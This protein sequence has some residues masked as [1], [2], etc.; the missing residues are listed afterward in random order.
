MA[1]VSSFQIQN[2]EV[3]FFTPECKYLPQY[4]SVKLFA[5]SQEATEFAKNT[6][7][8]AKSSLKYATGYA[9]EQDEAAVAIMELAKAKAEAEAGGYPL[10]ATVYTDEQVLKM[11]KSGEF[12][13]GNWDY[14]VEKIMLP[15]GKTAGRFIVP[16]AE[17]LVKKY[18]KLSNENRDHTRRSCV[19]TLHRCKVGWYASYRYQ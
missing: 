16:T 2:N 17:D 11:V 13:K 19:T 4:K 5:N 12:W 7:S 9:K 3:T 14:D 1:S 8:E 6:L 18:F 10:G 15:D